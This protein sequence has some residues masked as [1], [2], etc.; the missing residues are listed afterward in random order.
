MKLIENDNLQMQMT[1]AEF[2]DI[3]GNPRQRDTEQHAKK[4]LRAHLK[5]PSDVQKYVAIALLPNGEF[6]KLDGHTRAYCWQMGKLAAPESIIAH[7]RLAKD[8]DDACRMYGEYDSVTAAETTQDKI[9][10]AMRQTSADFE[11]AFL[12][13]GRYI[14]SLCLAAHGNII[15]EHIRGE[16]IYRLF[17]AMYPHLKK[18]DSINPSNTRFCS[19]VLAAALMTIKVYGDSAMRFW[20]LYNLDQGQK[21]GKERDAVQMLSDHIVMRRAAGT[22]SARSHTVDICG[23]ALAAYE[24]FNRGESYVGGL[25]AIDAAT[26]LAQN[27]K[28]R[29]VDP[30]KALS[31]RK[32]C[33]AG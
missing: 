6:V 3:P 15:P 8:M 31:E 22:M 28:P 18:L 33:V 16:N 20:N 19:G 17:D 5:S 9:F 30:R 12:R 4:A 14:T 7:V 21:I 13:N 25:K 29:V 1:V 32:L 27:D 2:C 26:W 24:R 23:R 11:S 10:G